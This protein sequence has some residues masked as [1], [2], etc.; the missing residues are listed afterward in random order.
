MPST[1]TQSESSPAASISNV[2]FDGDVRVEAFCSADELGAQGDVVC[3]FSRIH[4][5]VVISDDNRARFLL[6]VDIV[7][8][9]ESVFALF[10]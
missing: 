2:S 8:A 6:H 10:C 4:R 9:D 1:T 3:N 5:C 7:E